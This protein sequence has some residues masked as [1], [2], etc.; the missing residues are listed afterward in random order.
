MSNSARPLFPPYQIGANPSPIF[1]CILSTRIYPFAYVT[2]SSCCGIPSAAGSGGGDPPAWTPSSYQQPTDCAGS[3]LGQCCCWGLLTRYGPSP[4]SVA[5]TLTSL[6]SSPVW[7]EKDKCQWAVS[8]YCQQRPRRSPCSACESASTQCSILLVS[9]LQPVPLPPALHQPLCWSLESIPGYNPACCDIKNVW[10]PWYPS[11]SWCWSHQSVP[12]GWPARSQI[13]IRRGSWKSQWI[14]PGG[15]ESGGTMEAALIEGGPRHGGSVGWK[16]WASWSDLQ[17]MS[18]IAL[19]SFY[20][21]SVS[22]SIRR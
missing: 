17:N 8:V 19:C 6:V 14:F 4:G 16:K 18:C 7:M 3:S 10:W 5:G 1:N 2:M 21:R 22:V 13:T 15:M 9:P 12:P 20:G 11:G